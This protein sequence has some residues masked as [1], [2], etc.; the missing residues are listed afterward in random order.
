[1][2]E[3]RPG[4]TV[5]IAAH[6]ARLR[7]GLLV[8]AVQSV[9]QQT[10]Q[11]DAIIVVN[12]IGKRGAGWNRRTLVETV[13]TTWMAWLDSDDLWFPNHL[14]TLYNKAVETGAR[15]VY[16]WFQGNHDPLGH[17]GK[18]FN[19]CNPHHTTITALVDVAMAKQI[20]YEDTSAEG[21]FSD[22]DWK[23]IVRFAE[24]CCRE[25]YPMVH[26]PQKTWYW[27]QSGQ[28]SSGRPNQGDATT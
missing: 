1:M 26:I 24:I 7:N 6:P 3:L 22:E 19:P 23:F 12:D 9:C 11:P 10:L 20:S 15:Y 18:E 27:R 13:N 2:S 16:S 25:G 14:E 17:F 28:N 5:L 8:E 4:I 21:Q